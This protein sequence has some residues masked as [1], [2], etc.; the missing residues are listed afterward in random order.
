MKLVVDTNIVFSGMLNS[1]SRIGKILIS[2]HKDFELIS[3]EFLRVK[4]H[5]HKSRLLL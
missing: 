2:P 4:I 5:K 1:T 3:C